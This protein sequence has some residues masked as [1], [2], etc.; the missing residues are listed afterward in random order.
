MDLINAGN[1]PIDFN[2]FYGMEIDTLGNIWFSDYGAIHTIVTAAS[3]AWL[4]TVQLGTTEFQVFPNPAKDI[5]SIR[6]EINGEL[7]LQI[8][9]MYGRV[10]YSEVLLDNESELNISKLNSGVYFVNLNN[11]QQVVKV[12]KD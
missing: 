2:E 8:L 3:P 7:N 6:G 10:V 1:S 12:I 4:S 9:D 5:L 11:G